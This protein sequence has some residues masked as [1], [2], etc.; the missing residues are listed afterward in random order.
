MQE[1][2][3]NY[4]DTYSTVVTWFA[5][6]LMIVFAILFKRV[7]RQI[8]F[9]MAYPQAPIEMDMYMELPQGIQ[10]KHGNSKDHVLMLLRNI[11]GQKQA[12]RVWNHYL[13]S[14]LLEVGFIQSLVADCVFYRRNTIFIVYVDNCIFIG[15]SDEQLL[16]VIAELQGLGLK[17]EDQGHP[18]DYVGV[19]IKRLASGGFE[20]TQQAL[21]EAII[22]D[23][24][25]AGTPTKPVPAKAHVVLLA[26]KDKPKFALNF[27]YRSV[28]GKS[29]HRP[30]GPTSC[31][32][33]TRLPV[34][35]PTQ[36]S[37]TARRFCT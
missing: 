12:G 32:Q 20:F 26:F 22:N 8:D 27:D 15:D 16:S 6:W 35:L 14:K 29:W 23:V 7:M 5:I 19:N 30:Q 1:F 9:V 33:S 31:M 21:I 34:S 13:T 18:A 2:G 24:G 4:Y 10:T 28:T 37:P 11:Y 25:V 17:I 36:G 3:V